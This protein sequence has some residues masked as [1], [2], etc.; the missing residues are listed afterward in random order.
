MPI[1]SCRPG[2]PGHPIPAGR[3]ARAAL[4]VAMLAVL[5]AC[6]GGGNS[7]DGSSD[8]GGDGGGGGGGTASGSYT[9]LAWN[10]LGMHCVD[11][12][13]YSVF[14]ILPPYNNLRA[15][16]VLRD[17]GAEAVVGSGITVSYESA[18]DAS[19]S[20]NTSSAGKTNFWQWV[21]ALFGAAPAPDIGL[22]GNPTPSATPAPIHNDAVSRTC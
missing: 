7:S 2:R 3:R 20:I 21:Q 17:A 4:A 19:G 6:G 12:K 16:V 15:Q 5:A 1:P 13:D 14:S 8:G 11:G 9:V 22:T 18:A 10:D